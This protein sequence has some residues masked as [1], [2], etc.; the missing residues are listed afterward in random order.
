MRNIVI[1]QPSKGKISPEHTKLLSPYD[2]T[3][4]INPMIDPTGYGTPTAA[5]PVISLHSSS[6]IDN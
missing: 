2:T 5:T 6:S 3:T 4:E 1:Y